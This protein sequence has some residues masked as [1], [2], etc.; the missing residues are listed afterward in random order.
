MDFIEMTDLVA[1]CK[2]HEYEFAV[3]RD[4][5]GAIYL[6]ASYY[7]PD[8]ETGMVERQVTRRWF[9]SPAMTHSEI[10]QT[11]FKC[12][13]TSM[14][15]RAREWFKY[16]GKAVFG[17]HFDVEALWAICHKTDGRKAAVTP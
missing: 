11:A 5:R 7:E 15:H 1:E 9:L 2:H 6:Q 8:T 10:V 4:S 17:P 13:M 14:E 3:T 12:V 16:R